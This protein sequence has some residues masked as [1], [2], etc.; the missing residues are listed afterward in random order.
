VSLSVQLPIKP[1]WDGW[2]DG[3]S[4]IGYYYLEI[5]ELQPDIHN[6]LTELEPLKPIFTFRTNLTSHIDFP[7]FT[8][9]DTGMYSIL[10]QASDMANN[11]KIA[12]RLV[13]YDNGSNI[14]LTKP[15]FLTGEPINATTM[16]LGDGG[17]HVVS[18][19]PETGYMWQTSEEGNR[20]THI[21]VDWRNHFVNQVVE[22]KRLLNKVLPY[23]TQFAHLEDDGVL[24]S[25]K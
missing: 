20:K 21:I 23:P 9:N 13:L 19:I 10:L 6:E 25:K 3:L 5:F 4:G 2:S 17:M 18:A 14:T 15:G 24:R 8:P 22:R 16:K 12:R 11:S 1:T 7:T